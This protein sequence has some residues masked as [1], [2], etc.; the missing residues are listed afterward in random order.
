MAATE[1]GKP[2]KLS[3]FKEVS[4]SL[5]IFWKM[6]KKHVSQGRVRELFLGYFRSSTSLQ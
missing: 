4:E 6:L 3:F 1:H 2:G 5:E